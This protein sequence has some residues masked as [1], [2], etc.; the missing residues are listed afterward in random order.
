MIKRIIDEIN[1][2]ACDKLLTMLIQDERQYDNTLDENF[3]V[4]DYFK[5]VIKDNNNLL[6]GYFV[7]NKIIGYIFFKHTKDMGNVYLVDGMFVKEEYRRK[8]IAKSLIK[9]GMDELKNR[10]IDYIDINVMANNYI[11]F[12]L[13]KSLGFKEFR[14]GLRK[15]C[16]K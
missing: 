15:E 7:D 2:N 11:A 16:N 6:Y 14:I 8:G 10:N 3:V 4:K 1:A 12:N 5:K 13:Y 9:F